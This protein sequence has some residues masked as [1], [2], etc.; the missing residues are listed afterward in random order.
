[1]ELRSHH[2]LC[3]YHFQG[4][5]YSHDFTVRLDALWQKLQANPQQR[6]QIVSGPDDICSFCPH[7]GETGCEKG[8]Q[9]EERQIQIMDDRVLSALGLSRGQNFPWQWISIHIEKTVGPAELWYLCSGC[10]WLTLCME[11]YQAKR[12]TGEQTNS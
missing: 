5:G 4:K 9:G 1:M 8:G 10:E 7:V 3:L 12:R 6:V 11:R 2:L